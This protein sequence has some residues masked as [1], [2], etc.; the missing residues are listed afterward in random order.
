MLEPLPL[1]S[2][3]KDYGLKPQK[4]LGQNFLVDDLYLEKIVQ[5]AEV[6]REDTVLEIGAGLGSLT[7]YLADAAGE[8]VAVEIDRNLFPALKKVT[9]SFTNVHLVQGDFMEMD[10]TDLVFDDGYKVVANIPYYLTSNLVR[11]LMEASVRPSLVA[12][13]VQKEVAKRI[14][15]KPGALSLLALGVQ[16]YGKPRVAFTI[17]KGAFFPAPQVDSAT[18]LIELYPQ[19]RISQERLNNFF[20]LAKSGFAQK[21]KM[22][23]NALAGAPD[24]NHEQAMELLANTGIEPDRRAQT[25]NLE[26]WNT[27]TNHYAEFRSKG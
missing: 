19:P 10:I 4:G 26:E 8:V 15:A 16:V 23:H 13:T 7:R 5:A 22:L 2:M 27:L 24:I 6:G 18:L 9:K 11:R 3:L 20:L 25:L 12:L 1:Q 21:R 14:C 17:P